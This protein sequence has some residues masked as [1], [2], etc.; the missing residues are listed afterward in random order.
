MVSARVP[1]VRV[2]DDGQSR[3]QCHKQTTSCQGSSWHGQAV[4]GSWGVKARAELPMCPHTVQNPWSCRL[5]FAQFL[6]VNSSLKAHSWSCFPAVLRP[7]RCHPHKSVIATTCVASQP[8]F[9]ISTTRPW[10]VLCQTVSSYRE[11]WTRPTDGGL[12]YSGPGYEFLCP[13]SALTIRITPLKLHISNI[14]SLMLST[15]EK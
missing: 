13:L 1:W 6:A 2:A 7:T 15:A 3:R 11:L 9:A 14:L 4:T 5:L 8:A 12:I 10:N